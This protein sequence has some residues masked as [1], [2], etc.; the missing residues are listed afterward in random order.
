M[1]SL[2]MTV[3]VA[4]TVLTL[5]L[6]AP[7]H[8]APITFAYEGTV[9]LANG[10]AP[11]DAFL[12]QT[13]RIEYT[14][15]STTPDTHG[16]TARGIYIN[17]ISSL[18][19]TAG[20]YSASAGIGT[21]IA[22]NNL[23]GADSYQVV[24]LSPSGAPIGGI[25][26]ASVELSFSDFTQTAFADDSL[27]SVQPDPANFT[28]SRIFVLWSDGNTSGDISASPLTISPVGQV[29][30]PATLALFGLGLAGLGYMR[31]RRSA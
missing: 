13:L 19:L 11:F 10:G 23:G 5:P 3:A 8:S 14:F 30:E 12:G 6:A 9:N 21:I 31:R 29:P 24:S 18:T 17:A 22:N 15:E 25:P 27:P 2:L 26:L 28:T 16:S 1:K 20:S 4:A 7:S